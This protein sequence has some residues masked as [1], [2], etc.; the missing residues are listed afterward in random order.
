MTS[1]N[2]VDKSAQPGL[3]RNIPNPGGNAYA[4]E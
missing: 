2:V 3:D 4:L 1:S